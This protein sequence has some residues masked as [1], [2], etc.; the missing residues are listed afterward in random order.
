[1]TRKI[2]A[3]GLALVASLA[4]SV[5]G[6]SAA[7]AA[8]FH[9][10]SSH[11]F[12]SG[13]Q[14]TQHTFTVGVGFGAIKCKVATFTGT[15]AATTTTFLT[16]EPHYTECTDSFG[17]AVDV[18]DNGATYTFTNTAPGSMHIAIPNS[19]LIEIKVTNG[20]G[21]V[22][23]TVLIASQ[24]NSPLDYSNS[25]SGILVASTINNITST[26]VGGFFN[27]G[28]ADGAHTGGSYTGSTTITGTDTSGKAVTLSYS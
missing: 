25:G 18:S 17:R 22:V 7:S 28:V 9:S 3:L 6:V 12:L 11:T 8:D 5:V 24:T 1:M 4:P 21:A 20:G 14:T 2:K 26:T 10:T 23:C 13:G 16:L 19:K 27:C 15:S